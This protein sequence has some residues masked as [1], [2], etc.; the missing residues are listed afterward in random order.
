M[1]MM[2]S[3]F[4]LAAFAVSAFA[5]GATIAFPPDGTT[6]TA[7]QNF[8]IDIARGLTL[9]PSQEVS[10]AIGL[11]SCS[12]FG[13]DGNCS[14]VD[15]SE[16]FGD[17]LYAGPYTPT[18]HTGPSPIFIDFYQNFTLTVPANFTVGQASLNVAHFSLIGAGPFPN[19][20]V[21]NITLNVVAA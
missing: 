5:Q 16:I 6:V 15:V 17:I 13:F 10:V 19:L 14:T 18:L 12:S 11:L 8:T 2:K 7:G 4:A 1:M 21:K 3:I 20:E 9:T